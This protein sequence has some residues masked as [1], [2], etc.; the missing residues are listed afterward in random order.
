MNACMHRPTHAHTHPR[1]CTHT[2]THSWTR[3][4]D[5]HCYAK[6]RRVSGTAFLQTYKTSKQFKFLKIR[7]KQVRSQMSYFIVINSNILS[8]IWRH[9]LPVF[10]SDFTQFYNP[11]LGSCY[12]YNSG[13]YDSVTLKTSKPGSSQGESES[14]F[15]RR[16]YFNLERVDIKYHRWKLADGNLSTRHWSTHTR[17]RN[18]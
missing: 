13:W 15:W 18:P 14:S 5:V 7:I 6:F 9:S 16:L 17:Q 12:I 1:T 11:T 3:W 2:H 8:L 10:V 4:Q